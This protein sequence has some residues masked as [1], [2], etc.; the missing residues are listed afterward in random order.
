MNAKN[1]NVKIKV[2]ASGRKQ[3]T[4]DANDEKRI[5]EVIRYQVL[6]SATQD[7][8]GVNVKVKRTRDNHPEHLIAYMLRKDT[9]TAD[10]KRV[11]VDENYN[12][13][14]IIDNYDDLDDFDEEE[15]TDIGATY[16]SNDIFD[17]VVS[18]PVPEI[19][20]AIAAIDFIYDEAVSAGLRVKKLTGPEANVA[21]YKH[22]LLMGLKGFVNIGYGYTGGIVLDD[23]RLR[24]TWFMSL[25]ERQLSP[26]VIYFNS[27]KVFNMP[28]LPEIIGAG[29]RTFIGGIINLSVGQSEEVCKSFWFSV[30]SSKSQ[31]E[32]TLKKAESSKYPVHGAHGI[33][34]DKGPFRA[35]KKVGIMAVNNRFAC[36][37]GGGGSHVIANRNWIRMWETFN[38]IYLAPDKVAVQTSDYKY[39][40]AEGGGGREVV[41]NRDKVG[42]WETFTLRRTEGKR[43]SVQA[44]NG[45]YVCAEEGGNKPLVAN[46]NHMGDW[47][48][49]EFIPIRRIGLIAQ[50]GKYVCAEGGG[51]RELCANRDALRSWETFTMAELGDGNIAL[52][53]N[54]GNY[55]CVENNGDTHLIANRNWIRTWEILHM[56][57]LPDGQIALKASNGKYINATGENALIANVSKIGENEKFTLVEID[58]NLDLEFNARREEVAHEVM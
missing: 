12:V 29:A 40:C 16:G 56:E 46:R 28:L 51:G 44:F 26:A 23:G 17:F 50:N 57:Q 7:Y 41:A 10:V 2:F 27:C 53:V 39:L 42:A 22:Y 21:N 5:T 1:E 4:Y 6:P 47:E 18:T 45:Q 30:L 14:E 9:Y 35:D 13:R 54:S 36:A 52:Q 34:G 20:S 48:T 24:H 32:D 19:P 49:F 38:L 37:V 31:M 8:H 25:T 15:V 58:N 33:F 3:K 43:M 11:N 55:I